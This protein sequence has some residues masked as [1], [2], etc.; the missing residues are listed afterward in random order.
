MRVGSAMTIDSGEDVSFAI[1]A[2]MLLYLLADLHAIL[3]GVDH[4]RKEN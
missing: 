3:V 2:S 4:C 1:L